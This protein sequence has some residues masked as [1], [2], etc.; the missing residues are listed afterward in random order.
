MTDA[1]RLGAE[2][3]GCTLVDFN[4]RS[5][6]RAKDAIV[7]NKTAKQV[8][9]ANS[10]NTGYSGRVCNVKVKESVSALN[11][12]ESRRYSNL[13]V[14]SG[15]EGLSVATSDQDQ[16]GGRTAAC[17]KYDP[18]SGYAISNAEASMSFISDSSIPYDEQ[19]Q[20]PWSAISQP[21]YGLDVNID[22][23]DVQSG[24]D[25][26]QQL[27]SPGPPIVPTKDRASASAL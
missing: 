9:R 27:G 15:V 12:G 20:F 13:V 2:C 5:I 3:C 14:S 8:V 17:C 21:R 7:G 24:R 16:G 26:P 1:K 23:T 25:R 22:I 10:R 4:A 11:D 19:S 18:S 6:A